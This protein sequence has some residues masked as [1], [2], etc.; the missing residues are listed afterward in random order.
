MLVAGWSV[1]GQWWASRQ[2]NRRVTEPS[3]FHFQ[4]AAFSSIWGLGRPTG[5]RTSSMPI[6]ECCFPVLMGPL[7]LGQHSANRPAQGWLADGQL[8]GDRLHPEF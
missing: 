4:N 6:L 8:T 3:R 7:A 5:D 2:A 1:V